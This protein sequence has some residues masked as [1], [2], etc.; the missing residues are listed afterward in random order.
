[1]KNTWLIAAVREAT[2]G[3]NI[4]RVVALIRAYEFAIE[5]LNHPNCKDRD[6]ARAEIQQRE[7]DLYTLLKR[8]RQAA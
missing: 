5:I 3:A 2:T 1:M 8:R 4:H 6:R 7:A